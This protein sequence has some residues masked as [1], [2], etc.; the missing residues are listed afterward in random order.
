[1]KKNKFGA[2]LACRNGGTR[3]FGKPLQLLD[4][5]RQVTILDYLVKQ[6]R[7][8]KHVDTICLAIADS[9]DNYV[10]ADIAEKNGWQYIFGDT[11]DVLGRVVSAADKFEIDT[12]FRGSSESPF[13]FYELLDHIYEQHL[14]GGFDFS[15]FSNLP[16]GA[17]FELIK[18]EA[19]KISHAKGTSRHRSE[20]VT[21]YIFDHQDNFKLNVQKPAD[22]L[23]RSDV[24]ITVDYPEDLVFCRKVYQTLNGAKT[25]IKIQDV[26]DFWDKHKELRKPMEEIGV[27]WG[28]GRLWK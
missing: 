25:T 17:G 7:L 9:K 22:K 4:I 24:R 16:E 12:V 10:Y 19:L 1:M 26:I 28:H 2:I 18:A 15:E 3:L 14:N 5:E 6:I 20:L 23:Q 11:V 8:A 27:D 13:L 21:S